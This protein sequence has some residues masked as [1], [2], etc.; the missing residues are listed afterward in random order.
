MFEREITAYCVSDRR[1][2]VARQWD[3]LTVF[4][5]WHDN[6]ILFLK[7]P[8]QCPLVLLVAVV[9]I[10][11]MLQGLH[12]SDTW[13]DTGR[14]TLRSNTYSGFDT[15]RTT[16][17]IPHPAVVLL[18]LVCSLLRESV[19]GVAANF[20]GEH[21]DIQTTR[22]FHKL[23]SIFQIRKSRAQTIYTQRIGQH[24][25]ILTLKMWHCCKE[26]VR[27]NKKKKLRGP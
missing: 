27:K 1:E 26:L 25:K 22:R 5:G 12:H 13:S 7:A 10:Y 6:T 11:M 16:W 9:D 2:R 21:A 15:S 18:L 17:R 4:G 3:T 20:S 14:A 8:S 19:Y 23:L 24:P